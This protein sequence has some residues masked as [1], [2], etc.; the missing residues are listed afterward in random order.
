MS[1]SWYRCLPFDALVSRWQ[2]KLL[3]TVVR[4]YIHARDISWIRK[5]HQCQLSDIVIY[6]P[7]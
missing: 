6:A 4:Q 7:A 2:N 1:S 3:R 5:T